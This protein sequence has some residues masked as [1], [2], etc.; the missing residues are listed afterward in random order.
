MY[1]NQETFPLETGI[2][3]V[4]EGIDGVGKTTQAKGLSEALLAY[5]LKVLVTRE[6]TDGQFGQRLRESAR[7]GRLSAQ[8]ELELFI[9]D[10]KEHVTQVIQPALANGEI[11]ITDRYYF[12]TAAYQGARGMNVDAL[13]KRNEEIAPVPDLLVLLDM[14]ASDAVHRIKS[15]RGHTPD[16]FEQGLDRVRSIFTEI[17]S[18]RKDSCILDARLKSRALTFEILKELLRCSRVR[19]MSNDEVH[20]LRL[21][22]RQARIIATAQGCGFHV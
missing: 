8:E 22:L 9:N 11:V 2:L 7:S 1:Q 16:E 21:A 20:N 17:I 13:I 18:D 5:G 3:I 14:P 19:G 12:S 4:L 10:R 6:P 15:L